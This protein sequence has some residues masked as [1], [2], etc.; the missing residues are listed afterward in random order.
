M[1]NNIKKHF[2]I[3][4]INTKIH[5]CN[6]IIRDYLTYGVLDRHKTIEE[7]RELQTAD[8]D[9]AVATGTA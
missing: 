2:E 4:D 8:A 9:I 3:I 7:I 1:G 6:D 5:E